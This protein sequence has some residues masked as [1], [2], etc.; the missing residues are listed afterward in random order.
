[1]TKLWNAV[2]HWFEPPK[3]R[4]KPKFGAIRALKS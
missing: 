3:R 2:K 1:M 4:S